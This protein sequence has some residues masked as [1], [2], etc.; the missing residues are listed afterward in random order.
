MIWFDTYIFYARSQHAGTSTALKTGKCNVIVMWRV[1]PWWR[2]TLAL[3]LVCKCI[4]IYILLV[5]SPNIDFTFKFWKLF[6]CMDG[7]LLYEGWSG[8]NFNL[9]HI[10][11]IYEYIILWPYTACRNIGCS[12]DGKMQRNIIDDL[13]FV[14]TYTAASVSMRGYFY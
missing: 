13:A 11:V 6:A 4:F 9:T 2:H 8:K 14:T 7:H 1:S 3:L 5:V 12:E 10:S